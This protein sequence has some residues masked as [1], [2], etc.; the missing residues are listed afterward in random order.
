MLIFLKGGQF[1]V[2]FAKCKIDRD[3]FVGLYVP[4]NERIGPFLVLI[5]EAS[6]AFKP[7]SL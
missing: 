6:I 7:I 1:L 2:M 4:T 3:Q 5:R